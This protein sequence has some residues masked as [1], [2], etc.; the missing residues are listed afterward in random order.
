MSNKS[1]KHPT[2]K[3]KHRPN[4]QLTEAVTS[5]FPMFLFLISWWFFN[6]TLV[7]TSNR[8][9]AV[10]VQARKPNLRGAA[11][12]GQSISYSS[13]V[14]SYVLQMKDYNDYQQ[15]YH[16]KNI[17]ISKRFCFHSM[18][19]MR[20]TFYTEVA[21][22]FRYKSP[23]HSSSRGGTGGSPSG[24]RKMLSSA[25]R[26]AAQGREEPETSTTN[27]RACSKSFLKLSG[28]QADKK[29][30]NDT[31]GWGISN[32]CRYTDPIMR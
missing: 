8:W 7:S 32:I 13:L 9:Y 20:L 19:I 10:G 11:R 29:Y 25:L 16:P 31:V 14:N 4:Y 26:T 30:S 23:I 1:Y 3:L 12:C 17:R 2:S 18:R 28:Q 21:T 27:F 5:F 15:M 24:R 6:P 22:C